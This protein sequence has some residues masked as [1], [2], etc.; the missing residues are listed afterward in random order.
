MEGG[1]IRRRFGS[2]RCATIERCSP[3][4]RYFL[5]SA[6]GGGSGFVGGNMASTRSPFE[7]GLFG[8]RQRSNSTVSSTRLG[9]KVIRDDMSVLQ[10]GAL[11]GEFGSVTWRK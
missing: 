9:Y 1:E 11:K 8:F 5:A 6:N 7:E 3:S 4:T 2:E 10:D